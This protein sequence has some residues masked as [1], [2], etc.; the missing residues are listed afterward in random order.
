MLGSALLYRH[1]LT[2][3][4]KADKPWSERIENLEAVLRSHWEL[5]DEPVKQFLA[6]QGMKP[7]GSNEP[8]GQF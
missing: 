1:H 6:Q 3:T 5:F 7:R 4:D 8:A 2:A